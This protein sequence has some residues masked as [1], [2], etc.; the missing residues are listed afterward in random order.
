MTRFRS[1][2]AATAVALL[3]AFAV[4]SGCTTPPTYGG[5]P[6]STR[7]FRATSVKVNSVNDGINV[8]PGD[9]FFDYCDE[10]K[11]INI[12]FRVKMGVANSASAQVSVGANHWNGAFDQGLKAGQSHNYSGNEQAPVTF[13]DVAMPDLLDLAQGAKLEIVGVWAWK[14]EDDGILAASV[15]D[16]ADAIAPAITSALNQTLAKTSLPSDANQIVSAILSA[17]GNLGFFQL[18]GTVFTGLMNN[19]NISSDDVVG[20]AMYVGVGASG[21][22]SSIISTA[23]S[24][25]SFPAIA[26]PS[27]TVPPDIGGGAI[28]SLGSGAKTFSN[29]YTNAGV[30]G[31]HTTTYSFG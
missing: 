21:T 22:L 3:C 6:K 25:I 4:V 10:P 7:T 17:I 5:P 11:V 15:N 13:T 18:F 23:A 19:L 24:G 30:D 20:S 31:Q 1:R 12:G 28:F 9:C 14:V 2:Y 27:L 26:I 8:V 16:I 29:S